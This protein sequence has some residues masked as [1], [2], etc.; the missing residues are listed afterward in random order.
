MR[1]RFSVTVPVLCPLADPRMRGISQA[2]G[3]REAKE[4]N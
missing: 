1:G 4:V 3:W 2:L